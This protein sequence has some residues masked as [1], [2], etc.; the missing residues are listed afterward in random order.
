MN[1]SIEFTINTETKWKTFEKEL[2]LIDISQ[3]EIIK[4]SYL[5]YKIPEMN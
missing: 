5:K 2:Q 4:R 1:D 3:T